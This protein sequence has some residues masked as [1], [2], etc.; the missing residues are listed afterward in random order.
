MKGD[1][2]ESLELVGWCELEE[3]ID[4]YHAAGAQLVKETWSRA[5]R[6][7]SPRPSSVWLPN[8]VTGRCLRANRTR[9]TPQLAYI[10]ETQHWQG[11]VGGNLELSFGQ[12]RVTTVL[13]PEARTWKACIDTPTDPATPPPRG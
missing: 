8:S 3:A 7:R 13:R 2:L 6:R 5:V 1:G 11:K 9:I 10:V 12:L 4:R